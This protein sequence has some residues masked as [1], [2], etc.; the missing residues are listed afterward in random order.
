MYEKVFPCRGN[1]RNIDSSQIKSCFVNRDNKKEVTYSKSPWTSISLWFLRNYEEIAH[2]WAGFSWLWV[3]GIIL[4]SMV[5]YITLTY[6]FAIIFLAGVIL[7]TGFYLAIRTI[8]SH[9][10]LLEDGPEKDEARK[11]MTK[12]IKRRIPV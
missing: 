12:I 10:K 9:L 3:I 4:S 2:F 8:A 6:A 7:N 11:L 1:N 5:G